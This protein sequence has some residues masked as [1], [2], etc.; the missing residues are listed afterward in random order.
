VSERVIERWKREKKSKRECLNFIQDFESEWVRES[1]NEWEMR[2]HH[3]HHHDVIRWWD[4][5]CQQQQLPKKASFV[6]LSLSLSPS[7]YISKIKKKE[8]KKEKKLISE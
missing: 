6:S 2:F 8:R 4:S 7:L 3:H 1:E 5:L